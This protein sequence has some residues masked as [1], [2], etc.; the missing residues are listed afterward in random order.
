MDDPKTQNF[1]GIKKFAAIVLLISFSGII[2]GIVLRNILLQ[3]REIAQNDVTPFSEAHEFVE[4]SLLSY[5]KSKFLRDVT[6]PDYTE[7]SP[8]ERFIKIWEIKNSGKLVWKDRYMAEMRVQLDGRHR[9][10]PYRSLIPVPLTEPGDSSKISVS[11]TAPS[12]PG[13]Y[14]SYWKIMYF[15]NKRPV[16]PFYKLSVIWVVVKVVEK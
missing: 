1:T 9:L 4:D 8:G 15:Y 11:F 10:I 12:V 6:I 5:D 7:V 16:F 14:A 3:S 2:T 13:T